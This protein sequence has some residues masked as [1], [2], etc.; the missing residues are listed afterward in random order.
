MVG[1]SSILILILSGKTYTMEGGENR[2]SKK[3]WDS[4]SESGQILFISSIPGLIQNFLLIILKFVH[5]FRNY[6][7]SSVPDI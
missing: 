4:E 3:P 7:P 2:I 6:C 5:V 1:F